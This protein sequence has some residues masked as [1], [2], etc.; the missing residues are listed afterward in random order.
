[1]QYLA[2]FLLLVAGINL[3]CA[4]TIT[5]ED[6]TVGAIFLEN[7]INYTKVNRTMLDEYVA[8]ANAEALERSCTSG[9][10]NMSDL[11][12][13]GKYEE[14]VDISTW[15]TS[16]VT[17]MYCM[18][19]LFSTFN[20][21]LSLWDTSNVIDM[22]YVFKQSTQFNGNIS[23]WNTTKVTS[24]E[25]MFHDASAFDK[26]LSLWDTSAVT[27]MDWMFYDAGKFNRDI[28][29]WKTS[30]VTDMSKMFYDAVSFNQSLT[31]WCV[32]SSVSHNDFATNSPMIPAFHP[33]WDGKGCDYKC[34]NEG[35][36]N[37]TNNITYS[38]ICDYPFV[39][40]YCNDSNPTP[41]PTPAPALEPTPTPTTVP[42][43]PAPTTVQTPVPNPTTTTLTW[44]MILSIAVGGVLFISGIVFTTRKLYK[45]RAGGISFIQP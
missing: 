24:M 19:C 38:C 21:E 20:N 32:N 7:G 10:T 44:W 35:L 42:P 1:M 6:K 17:T 27:N 36:R 41:A 15:D 39:G 2:I 30:A 16:S 26:D 18:F 34:E 40:L 22:S 13:D 5:C 45:K 33:L 3:A 37:V 4:Q 9:V 43:T 31:N 25:N 29:L 28:S 11:F 23:T 14:N 8:N 12:N